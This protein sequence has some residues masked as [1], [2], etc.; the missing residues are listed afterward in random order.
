M[1]AAPLAGREWTDVLSMSLDGGRVH[2]TDL[3]TIP[4]GYVSTHMQVQASPSGI[5]CYDK[6]SDTCDPILEAP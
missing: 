3:F 2:P 1:H 4:Q 5:S 6:E